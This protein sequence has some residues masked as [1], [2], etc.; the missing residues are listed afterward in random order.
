MYGWNAMGTEAWKKENL[1]KTIRTSAPDLLGVQ[2]VEGHQYETATSIGSDYAVVEDGF[3][4]HSIIYRT[5]QLTLQAAGLERIY[6]EDQWGARY[7][8]WSNFVHVN[9]RL[10]DHFNTHLCVCD[11]A[12]LYQSAQRLTEVISAHRR[13]GSVLIL[14]GDFNV[15]GGF[16][17]SQAIRFLRGELGGNAYPLEDTFRV[18]DPSGNGETFPGGKI[19]YILA[20][21]GTPV[22]SAHIDRETVPYGQASDHYAINAVIDI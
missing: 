8:T 19:D 12:K 11:E 7:V 2:E 6:E 22:W 3:N 5:S 17:N 15:F 13:P 4:S 9:G 16:E 20:D 14:T 21:Y 10:I 1:F 18:A